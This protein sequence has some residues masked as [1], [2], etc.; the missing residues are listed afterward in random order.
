MTHW[1]SRR[2]ANKKQPMDPALVVVLGF[3]AMGL[4]LIGLGLIL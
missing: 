2:E 3:L 4:I 1:I